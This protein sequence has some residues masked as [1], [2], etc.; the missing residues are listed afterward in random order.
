LP[1]CF[2]GNSFVLVLFAGNLYL[3]MK[4]CQFLFA[5]N[6][7]VLVLLAGR[8]QVVNYNKMLQD[9]GIMRREY[10]M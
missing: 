8:I 2:A 3:G 6:Y 7:F 1:V 10:K 9:G 4:F 5:G